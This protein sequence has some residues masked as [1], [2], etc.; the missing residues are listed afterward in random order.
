LEVNLAVRGGKPAESA[1]FLQGSGEGI[2][3]PDGVGRASGCAGKGFRS[4]ENGPQS[5]LDEHAQRLPIP[6]ALLLRQ[7]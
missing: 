3:S 1:D 6:A 7:V 5:I 2:V 4:M